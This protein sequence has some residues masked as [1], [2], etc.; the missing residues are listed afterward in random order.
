MKK[1]SLSVLVFFVSI[2]LSNNVLAQQNGKLWQVR[3]TKD[4]KVA[5]I[6]PAADNMKYWMSLANEGI[7][8][9]N[10]AIKANPAVFLGSKV[11]SSIT[12]IEDSPD[13][14]THDGTDHTQSEISVFVNPN[15]NMHV[16]NSNN[17]TS[18]SGG[19]I[20]T[21]YGTSSFFSADAG[22]TWTGDVEGTGGGN[23]GDPAAAIDL[24]G[25]LYSGF[26]HS[27]YGQGVAYSADGGT[28]WTSVLVEGTSYGGMLDKNHLTVDNSPS[29]PY[30]GNVYTAWTNLDGGATENEICISYSDDGG[31]TYS[32]SVAVSTG[33]NAGSHNQGVNI[34]TGPNGEVYVVWAIYDDWY[35]AGYEE[36]M[37]LAISYDGGATWEP[38]VR[39]IDNLHGIRADEPTGHRVNSFPS[40]A[41]DQLTGNIYVVWSNYGTPGINTGSNVSTY[42]IKSTDG[43]TNWSTPV[44][45][46]Q[47]DFVD[48][49][50][51]YLPWVSCDAATG[52]ISVVFYDTRNVSGN[53][54]ETWTSVS[55]DE[56]ETWEDFRVS[57][58]SFTTSA[59]PGLAGGYMGDYLGIASLNGMIYPTWTDNRDG[60]F[61]AY[62]S[63]ISLNLRPRP[64][65]LNAEIVDQQTGATDLIWNF[66]D[67]STTFVE[68]YV[69]RDD[70]MIGSTSD[71]VF[72]DV[73]PSYGEHKYQVSAMHTDGESSKAS[74]YVI[75][76]SASIVVAPEFLIDT[77]APN[78]TST[79]ILTVSNTGVLDLI[80][81]LNTEITSK[82]NAP[83]VYCD[84]SGGGDEYISGVVFG[85]INN[86]G[87]SADGYHDYTDLSTDVNTSETYELTV[88]NGNPWDSD[89]WGVW[90][91]W[92]QDGDFDDAD[93]NPVCVYSEGGTTVS[94][95]ITVPDD[96]VSGETT[97]RIRVKYSGSDCGDPCGTT[98][99]GEVEDYSINVIGWLTSDVPTN[100][101]MPGETIYIPVTFDATDFLPGTYGA[102]LHFESNADNAT[103][104]DVPVTMVVVADLPLSAN[105]TAMP[106]DICSGESSILFANVTGGTSTYTYNWTDNDAFTSSDQNPSVNPSVTTTYYLTVDDGENTITG[107]VTVFVME[108]PLAPSTPT[109]SIIVGND[110]LLKKYATTGSANAYAYEWTITPAEAGIIAGTTDS[111][112]FNP[113]ND[114]VGMAYIKVRA[115]NDCGIGEWSEELEIE[116]IEGLT[117]IQANNIELWA[118]PNPTEGVFVFGFDSYQEDY[119]N[120][121]IYNTAGQIVY[122]NLNHYAV[123]SNS[124]MIDLS[125]QPAGMYIIHVSG[126]YV[127]KNIKVIK[128]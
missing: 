48:N 52:S 96:A 100:T 12:E 58:V 122:S 44:R 57:D 56:G 88:T 2:L 15:D 59:I 37:G 10:P 53:D 118:Y 86:N 8:P 51:A 72:S 36:A 26:I 124:M 18:W 23:S 38:A 120:I 82:Y 77:L 95:D 112:Y 85:D 115:I 50:A 7:V 61:K 9:H 22:Q 81:D 34:Q 91:D 98:T 105:P 20:G 107:E 42:L 70:Q 103:M 117:S 1:F 128:K 78:Q 125:D 108:E 75:W 113:N 35:G 11:N 43:G 94:W 45:V 41:V 13:V 21:L 49:E 40:M 62:T 31:L 6:N 126:N 30:A 39:I 66:T 28:T 4:G 127:S 25:R 68:F 63:P 3:Q 73:L 92:N 55:T 79:H 64:M 65:A 76:G 80:F 87:T 54:V 106:A 14:T 17:S 90:I 47:G 97:M 33:V 5:I 71:T 60:I 46:N 102:V 83:K 114:Y 16:F 29:S 101:V 67:T 69:Y 119:L 111:A 93:E 104:V 84:A 24:N 123:A 109:G 99:Y 74:D 32:P 121:E 116:I 89:D 19:T 27:N 110:N